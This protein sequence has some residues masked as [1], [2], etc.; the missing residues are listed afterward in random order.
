[1]HFSQGDIFE[2]EGT[3]A[4]LFGYI[5]SGSFRYSTSGYHIQPLWQKGDR[6]MGSFSQFSKKFS[7]HVTF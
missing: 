4:R 1:M 7:S 5:E 6:G 3:A 2:T